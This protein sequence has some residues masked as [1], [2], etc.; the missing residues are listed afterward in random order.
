MLFE[1]RL[2]PIPKL[3]KLC[4]R[5]KHKQKVLSQ[6]KSLLNLKMKKRKTALR[7]LKEFLKTK[8]K[9]KNPLPNL[10]RENI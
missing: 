6:L 3:S 1:D 7:V 8:K 5:N 2:K 4:K 10:K 9:Y